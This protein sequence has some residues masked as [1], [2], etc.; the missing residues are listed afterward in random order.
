MKDYYLLGYAYSTSL[1]DEA[2]FLLMDKPTAIYR[3]VQGS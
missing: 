2:Y 3:V 1:R